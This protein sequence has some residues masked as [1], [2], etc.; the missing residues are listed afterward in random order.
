MFACYLSNEGIQ[1]FPGYLQLP[2]EILPATL[3]TAGLR[4]T[5][6]NSKVCRASNL[7]ESQE[8]KP[9]ETSTDYRKSAVPA[10]ANKKAEAGAGL[11]AKFQDF[12]VDMVNHLSKVGGIILC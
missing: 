3:P 4:L 9:T 8:R 7:Q 2:P 6:Q 12:I 11:A 1:Y 10:G 5:G